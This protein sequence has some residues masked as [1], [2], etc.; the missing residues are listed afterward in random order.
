M[1]WAVLGTED[2]MSMDKLLWVYKTRRE[3]ADT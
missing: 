3:T 2:E 1:K